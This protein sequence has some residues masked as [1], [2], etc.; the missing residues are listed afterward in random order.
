M[1]QADP[2]TGRRLPLRICQNIW[3]QAAGPEEGRVLP[4]RRRAPVRVLGLPRRYARRHRAADAA[5]ARPGPRPRGHCRWVDLISPGYLPKKCAVNAPTSAP[6]MAPIPLAGYE[7]RP[8]WAS[9]TVT[10]AISGGKSV[11]IVV[12]SSLKCLSMKSSVRF[13]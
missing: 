12:F 8:F 6:A 10:R 13:R 7:N 1:P 4:R 5:E 11:E 3:H 2:G 9:I